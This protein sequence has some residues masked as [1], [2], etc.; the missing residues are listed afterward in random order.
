MSKN[1]PAVA[2]LVAFTR[3]R[4]YNFIADHN[5]ELALGWLESQAA[6]M[7]NASFK[8]WFIQRPDGSIYNEPNTVPGFGDQYFWDFRVPAAA[9]YFVSSILASVA[10][11]AVDGTFQD[12]PSGVPSEHP[13]LPAA[14]NLTAAQLAEVQLAT[15]ETGAL[16]VDLLVAQNKYSWHAFGANDFVTAGPPPG[17]PSACTA[18]MRQ[19]CD[20]SYQVRPLLMQ[21]DAT[22]VNQSVAAFLVVRPPHGYLGWGVYSD[23]RNWNDAFLLQAGE[24]LGLCVELN[25]GMFVRTWSLG[26]AALDCNT[27]TAQ[28]PFGTLGDVRLA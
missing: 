25:S 19:Y 9:N 5:Q 16:L 3:A 28:L 27:W 24:L 6:V 8:H 12:D 11:P 26:I 1:V 18:W 14:T 20:V 23:D 13:A 4:H 2:W 17:Q 10:D 15:Q 7:Y 21:F 22:N